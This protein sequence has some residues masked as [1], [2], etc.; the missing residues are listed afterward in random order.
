M[1]DHAM[2]TASDAES[3]T[4]FDLAPDSPL[5]KEK[6]RA[7]HA[8]WILELEQRPEFT[9]VSTASQ[10]PSIT[11]E[12]AIHQLV[13]LTHD[14]ALD[15]STGSHCWTTAC[16]FLETASR[17]A[18]EQQ[19]KL[20]AFLLA[21]RNVTLMHPGTNEPWAFEDGEGA[22]W[23]DLPTFGYTIADEMGSFGKLPG[24][25]GSSLREGPVSC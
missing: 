17:T 16:S 11:I 20:I 10:N 7:A 8:K 1:S 23:Q 25:T 18:P 14:S 19:G 4:S 2:I 21:L 22:V 3:T 6:T 12:A 13:D 15:D 24:A 5:T 9:L